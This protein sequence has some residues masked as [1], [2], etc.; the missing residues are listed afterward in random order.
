MSNHRSQT[1]W[2]LT[3]P[4]RA[5]ASF[6]DSL[7]TPPQLLALGEPAH[8]VD[9]FPAWRNRIFRTLVEN[10]GYRS[11]A[12]ESDV[13]AGQR[14]DAYLTTGEEPLD[15]ATSDEETLDDIMQRGF[16]HG[17]GEVKANRDL[18]TWLREFNIGRS[19]ADRVRFYGFDAPTENMWAASPRQALLE[20]HTF[21]VPQ[22]PDLPIDT[23]T[24]DRLCDDDAH[25]TNPAAALD[26]AQS[27]GGSI[28]AKELRWLTDELLTL[29]ET[30]RPRL[31]VQPD[32]YWHAR[33]HART[34]QGLLRYH[35]VMADGS[36]NRVARMLSLR[37]LM[38]ADNLTAIAEREALR[39]PTLVFAHNSHLQ[40]HNSQWGNWAWVP[41]GVHVSTRMGEWYAFIATAVGE[42]AGLPTPLPTTLEGWLCQQARSPRLFATPVLER[43]LPSSLTKR[44]DTSGNP[45]YFPLKPEYLQQTDGVLFL[46]SV[47]AM[48]L[49]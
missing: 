8:S 44:T 22:L 4:T 2:E 11:I 46:P 16:S 41:A 39:G 19:D 26:P 30:E 48:T 15:P 9:A 25:W 35:A 23:A 13:L 14:V 28:N 42:G 5:L 1:G 21:L 49:L 6:F 38:M 10:H 27:V 32:D 3:D 20:L 29:L 31:E 17:F 33:L 43:I 40:R 36:P 34:A 47:D 45:G 37:D 12:L 7:P 18:V 24:L